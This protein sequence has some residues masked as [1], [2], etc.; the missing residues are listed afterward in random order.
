MHI[1]MI[2]TGNIFRSPMAQGFLANEATRRRLEMTVSSAGTLTGSQPISASALEVMGED[3]LAVADHWSRQLVTEEVDQ[4]D[5]VV[6]MARLHVREAVVLSPAAWSKAFTLK[7]LVRRGQ[8]VGPRRPGQSVAEWLT[9]IG[10]GR[11]RNE[12]LGSSSEDDVADPVAAPMTV[13]RATAEEIRHLVV[14]LADLLA[15]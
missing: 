15:P 3:A 6:G 11:S 4:A 10:E 7:E 5:I 2:C 12:L 9:A 14:Q 1:L 8:V 13:L